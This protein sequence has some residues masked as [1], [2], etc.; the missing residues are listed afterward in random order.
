MERARE[1]FFSFLESN[2]KLIKLIWIYF[3]LINIIYLVLFI[4]FIVEGLLS[5]GHMSDVLVYGLL[6]S[7][8]GLLSAWIK[9]VFTIIGVYLLI[10]I[11]LTLWNKD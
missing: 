5:I 8:T 4:S 9:H 11:R 7:T 2:H 3:W 10:S 1:N 6:V